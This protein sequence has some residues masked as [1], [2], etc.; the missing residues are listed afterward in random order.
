MAPGN[1]L[2]VL[3]NS[4]S[5][6]SGL[7][8]SIGWAAAGW[9][10]RVWIIDPR[11]SMT[12][13]GVGGYR[14]AHAPGDIVALLEELTATCLQAVDDEGRAGRCE[15]QLLVIDDLELAAGPRTTAAFAA[16]SELLPL[17]V[18]VGLSV[19]VARRVSGS[20]RAAFDP[21]L[22]RLLELCET[23]VL[24]SGDPAEGP[25]IGGLRPRVRPPGR[26]QLVLGGEPAAEIQSAWLEHGCTQQSDWA[27]AAEK[28]QD[29]AA[30]WRRY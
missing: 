8:R 7:L 16:L 9:G 13:P 25:V 29:P 4:G 21:F 6:R 15:S 22:A 24:L 26:G 27:I 28:V 1:H 5:G 30:G 19:V 18:D 14:R 23:G 12:M 20:S 2:L 11:R 3:G 17:A 10:A